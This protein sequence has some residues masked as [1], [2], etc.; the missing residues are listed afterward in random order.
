MRPAKLCSHSAPHRLVHHL[1][2]SGV[3]ASISVEPFQV[4]DTR[5]PYFQ[6]G[7]NVQKR[8]AAAACDSPRVIPPLTEAEIDARLVLVAEVN[9]W[10]AGLE[11]FIVAM[12]S[13]SIPCLKHI[14]DQT[15]SPISWR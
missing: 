1:R 6:V 12:V 3:A 9:A 4:L 10:F 13:D 15:R 8:K 11:E 7:P 5:L 14:T 2:T